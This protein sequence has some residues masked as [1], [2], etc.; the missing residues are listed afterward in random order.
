MDGKK[1]WGTIKK[2]VAAGV[3]VAAEKTEE[4]TKLGKAKLDILAIRR[5]ITQK[6]TELGSAIY[7]A[8]KDGRTEGA[9]TSGAVKGYIAELDRLDRELADKQAQY[10]VLRKK[11]GSDMATMKK[12]AASGVK[13]IKKTAA[14]GVKNI[15]KTAASTVSGIKKKTTVKKAKPAEK[16]PDIPE[17]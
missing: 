15:K 9:F 14:S 7:T 16:K 1:V 13:N 2:K 10:E 8:V 11:A 12:K 5:S 4:Y 3:A 6:R 17:S